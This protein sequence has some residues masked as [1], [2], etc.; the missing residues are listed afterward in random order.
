MK[1][2]QHVGGSLLSDTETLDAVMEGSIDFCHNMVSYASGVIPDLA[3][4]AVPGYYA[5]DNYLAFA[6]AV[7]QPLEA[8]Y[9]KY[10]IKYLGSN[11]QGTTTFVCSKRLIT[12]PDD[13]KGLSFRTSGTWLGKAMENWGASAITIPLGDLTT[14][15]ERGT[16]DGTYTGWTITGPFALYEVAKYVT[17]TSITESFGNL[18]MSMDTWNSLTDA[19]KA[20]IEE[21][22]KLYI[23][24]SYHIGYALRDEYYS[25]MEDAG[26]ELY[27]LTAAEEK[28]F[29]DIS[30]KLFDEIEPTLSPDGKALLAILK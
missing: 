21:A 11:Y 6:A 3:L 8:I 1:I 5:G 9:A 29:T 19:Q 23:E 7:Q 12:K 24:E 25:A 4:L 17:F 28:V 30:L 26:T 14:A 27:T 22:A 10:D 20:I 18:L 2:E 16:V 13:L 15:L